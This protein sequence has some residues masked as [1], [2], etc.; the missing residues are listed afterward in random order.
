SIDVTGAD[1]RRQRGTIET[2]IFH[3]APLAFCLPDTG[4]IIANRAMLLEQGGQLALLGAGDPVLQ[5][6]FLAAAAEHPGQ[7]GVQIGYHE[8]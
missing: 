7:V 8:A 4:L 6:G 1:P 2:F 5:E 3:R